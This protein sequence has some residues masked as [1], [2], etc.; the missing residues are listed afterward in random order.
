MEFRG[1]P[2][3]SSHHIAARSHS[4]LIEARSIIAG[5]INAEPAD[6]VFTNNATGSINLA[7][8]AIRHLFGEG[9]MVLIS[10][11]EHHSNILPHLKLTSKGA[12]IKFVGLKDGLIDVEELR[13]AL[14]K[15]TKLVAVAQC[16]NVLGNINDVESIGRIVTSYN[17]DIFYLVDGAQAVAHVPVD[18]KA[19]NADF[20]AFSG[21]KMYGPDGVGALYVSPAIRHLLEPVCTGGGTVRDIAV[22]FGRNADTAYPDYDGS[23][24]VLEGGTPNT[25]NI[26]ALSKAVG[27]LDRIGFENIRKHEMQLTKRLCS[28]IV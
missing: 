5:F 7:V 22:T 3:R 18:V 24:S 25:S 8:D 9:D 13:R 14:T 16:S 15:R 20:Y 21:H 23:L 2:N 17:R 1:N 11:A 6:I 27:F 19:M 4:L 26:V 28:G 12:M 10:I